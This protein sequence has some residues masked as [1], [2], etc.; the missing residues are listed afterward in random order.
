MLPPPQQP[1]QRHSNQTSAAADGSPNTTSRLGLART[2]DDRSWAALLS[3]TF[4]RL[5]VLPDFFSDFISTPFRAS[6]C[7]AFVLSLYVF[8]LAALPDR[9]SFR[10][11]PLPY[12]PPQYGTLSKLLSECLSKSVSKSLSTSVSRPLSN[13][14]SRFLSR[15][16][17]RS[18]SQLLARPLA[19]SLADSLGQFLPH[20]IPTSLS[21]SLSSSL[22]KRLRSCLAAIRAT[23]RWPCP[24]RQ[25]R[26]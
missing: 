12:P 7:P 2:R 22:S 14:V 26:R 10:E 19:R 1:M 5:S 15:P 17:A 23:P 4:L 11:R 9:I 16:L 20:C 6:F 8:P 18:L 3:T 21:N 25:Q 13:C 24:L